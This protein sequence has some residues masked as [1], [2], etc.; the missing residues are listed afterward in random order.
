MDKG[1]IFIWRKLMDKGYYKKSQYVHLWLHLIFRANHTKTKFFWNGKEQILERGQLITGRKKLSEE[2]GIRPGTVENILK[3]LENEQQI[4]QQKT[5]LFRL[6]TIVNYDKLQ[7]YN[8]N[9][10]NKMTTNEQQNDNKMT[11]TINLKELKELNI[12]KNKKEAEKL[13]EV[14]WKEYPKKLCKEEAKKKFIKLDPD[15]E[16]TNNLIRTVKKQIEL[17]M[18]DTK[19]NNKY[20]PNCATWINQKRYLDD[21]EER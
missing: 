13:F 15:K 5:N 10:D 4:K 3:M 14:F 17:G 16:D 9:N 19:E 12:K 8:S 20:C 1:F 11:H 21:L 2:T 6:I 7:N 18:I